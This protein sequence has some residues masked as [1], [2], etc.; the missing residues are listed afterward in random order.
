MKKK[1]LGSL[2]LLA[3]S[4]VNASPSVQGYYQSKALINYA[5][6]KVQQNKAEYFM[7]DY[8]LTLPAQSQAQFV[9]YNS[10]LGYFQANNP[11]V[12][13][14]EFQQIVRKVNASALEDQYICRVDSAGMK[15][16]YAAK[17]GQNCTAHY[18]EEPRAMSQKGTKVSFFRRWD[19]DPTQAH[20]DIQSYDTDT[21]TGDEVITQDY[22]LKFEGRWI[23]SSV[24]VITS[25]VE[26]VSGGSA[27]AYDVASYNFSG[28]RSGI[29]S[30]GEGLLYSEHPYFITDD[31]NQQ[32]ADGVTKHI[33]KTTFNT[34]SLI[35]GNYKGRNLETNGPFYLVNRDY[36]KA[37]TLEDNST[38]YFVSDPQ[39]FA[40]VESMSGPSDSW[41]WQDETQWD[42]EKG[43]DQASGGDWVAHAF[44]NTHNL[45]SLSPTYCMIEDIAE[46]RPVTEYQSE[47]GTSLWNPSMHDCQAKEPGTVPKVYTHFINSYGEDIAFSSLRQ[48]AKDMIHVREQHPQGNETL[49]SLG[50]VK[51]MKA[52]SRYNEIKAELSQRYSWSKPYDILK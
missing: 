16:T 30:G 20:F 1:I 38:A 27:T 52:S 14:S 39:I 9:S 41:V 25:E 2:I 49:L 46:G 42:P 47:D 35:D 26:L 37:Y 48:S 19:F 34:F 36:V 18:D 7:L 10:A 28:P 21:A 32:S 29:I 13:E 5:T 43:T 4:Q 45:V 3:V 24:R 12:S 8:A 22:L 40:I 6:N 15:L 44:N 31:E 17:R 11:S 51:A 33:T 23:G 50:D